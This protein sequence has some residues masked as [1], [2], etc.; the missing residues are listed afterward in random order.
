MVGIILNKE[1]PCYKHI[2]QIYPKIRKYE[3]G[4]VKYTCPVCDEIGDKHQV[5]P[6][7]LRCPNCGVNFVWFDEVKG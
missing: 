2:V 5:H 7:D 1:E 4:V 6:S 3:G